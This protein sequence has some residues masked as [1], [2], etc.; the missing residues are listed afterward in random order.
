MKI[1]NVYSTLCYDAHGLPAIE[2]SIEVDNTHTSRSI[3][4]FFSYANN[5]KSENRYLTSQKKAQKA[6]DN[7]NAMFHKEL[8]QKD[9]SIALKIIEDMYNENIEKNAE[10]GNLFFAISSAIIKALSALNNQPNYPTIAEIYS[11]ASVSLPFPWVTLF[12]CKSSSG[13][14]EYQIMPVGNESFSLALKHLSEFFY[15]TQTYLATLPNAHYSQDG[16]IINTQ[17]NDDGLKIIEKLLKPRDKKFSLSITV[18]ASSFF[19]EKTKNYNFYGT[20]KTSTE[21][22]KLYQNWHKSYPFL[23]GINDG[24]AANDSKDHWALLTA[25]M[26]TLEVQIGAIEL[27]NISNIEKTLELLENNMVTTLCIQEKHLSKI[28]DLIQIV[29]VCKKYNFN[30][31][32]KCSGNTNSSFIADL[33]VSSSVGQISLPSLYNAQNAVLCNQLIFIE[34]DL[35]KSAMAEK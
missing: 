20:K 22:I 10:D 18:S 5:I 21:M 3:A 28:S 9:I 15:D 27:C 24:L 16:T 23:Q 33:A 14:Q 6:F 29:Q 8:A 7:C 26:S 25:T 13:I 35:I 30:C 1:T 11:I 17:K 2:Y 19:D 4:S 31:I 34:E 32:L 12:K